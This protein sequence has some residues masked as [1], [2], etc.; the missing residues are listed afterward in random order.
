METKKPG[1][2]L[3]KRFAA[4]VR[5]AHPHQL[6]AYNLSPSFNWD[7]AGLTKKE[8][9]TF[10]ASFVPIKWIVF[11]N[12]FLLC[13][14]HCEQDDL[15]KYGYVWQ[16][17]TLAGFHCNAFSI[18]MFARDY[19]NRHIVAYVENIQRKEREENVE[20]LTHQKVG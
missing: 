1:I 11:S 16:F 19:A 20:T 3:A 17:I 8:M 6:F 5:V 14:P 13:Y 4:G 10:Q 15:G 9:R 18:D 12:I 7:A 2:E